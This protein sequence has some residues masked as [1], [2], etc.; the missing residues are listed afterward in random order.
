MKQVVRC[1][2]LN[3]GEILLVKHNKD[4]KWT[5]PWWHVENGET[6]HEAIEREIKEEF[7]LKI[8]LTNGNK[9]LNYSNIT[10]L[11]KPISIYSISYNSLKH[12][13]VTNIEYIFVAKVISWKL[14]SQKE[15]IYD[16]KWFTKEEIINNTSDIYP[17]ILDLLELL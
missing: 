5:L 10:D 6:I 16:Y 17:Q 11:P 15:E 2:L 12:W 7:K 4:A 3:K 9:Y 14:I 1:F 13:D 8:K